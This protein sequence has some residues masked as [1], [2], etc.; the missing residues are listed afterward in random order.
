MSTRI[1]EKLN[2]AQREYLASWPTSVWYILEY[3][4]Y[5]L[6]ISTIALLISIALYLYIGERRASEMETALALFYVVLFIQT[7]GLAAWL[8]GLRI[9]RKILQ[10]IM[11]LN[12]PHRD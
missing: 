9:V 1:P 2:D 12:S 6:Y 10:E 5:G 3:C 11:R 4:Q 7:L 8:S